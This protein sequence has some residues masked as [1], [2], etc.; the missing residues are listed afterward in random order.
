[1]SLTVFLALCILGIDFMIY[2]FFQWTYG[3]KRR[4]QARQLAALKTAYQN[5]SRRPYVSPR[6]YVVASRRAASGSHRSA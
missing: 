3:D 2:A 4:A 6:P 5:Q 1:M